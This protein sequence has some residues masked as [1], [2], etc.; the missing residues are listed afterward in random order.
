MINWTEDRDDKQVMLSITL[1]PGKKCK[2]A[3]M[4]RKQQFFSF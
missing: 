3:Q 4:S 1:I 2:I